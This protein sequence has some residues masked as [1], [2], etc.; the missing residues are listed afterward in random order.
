MEN[1]LTL[2]LAGGQ[3]ERLRPLTDRR[4]KSVMPF[5]GRRLI[6]D[7]LA[8]CVR[9]GLREVVVLTQHRRESVRAHVESTWA[10]ELPHLRFLSSAEVGRAYRGTADAVRAALAHDPEG[11]RVLVLASDH[12]YHMHYRDLM[13]DHRAQRADVTMSVVPVPRCR[14]HTLGCV[15]VGA[16]GLVQSFKEK[17]SDPPTMPGR[18]DMSLASMGI[19]L[20]QRSALE[21]F[22]YEYPDADDFAKHVIPG[23]LLGGLRVGTHDF[24]QAG[25][26]GYWRDIGDVD[27][28]HAALMDLLEGTFDDGE[29]WIGPRSLVAGGSLDRCV[30]G[31]DVQVGPHAELCESV[32]LDGVVVGPAARLQRVVVEEG[33]RIPPQ[34]R[35]GF[36]PAVDARWGT[37]TES[38]LVVVT[39]APVPAPSEWRATAAG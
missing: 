12:V 11:R 25:E 21:D 3:G 16:D 8:N 20:F 14:A 1:T 30:L 22:L 9:T 35:I 26:P 27:G 38:G 24:A 39:E 7:T 28:Y 10:E 15:R 18:E 19:Y 32:L 2:V 31:R 4:A 29:S 5:A 33:V 36:N 34:A 6:D 37:V 17:P 23:M 13:T